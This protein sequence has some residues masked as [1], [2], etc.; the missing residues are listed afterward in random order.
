MIPFFFQDAYSMLFKIKGYHFDI[1]CTYHKRWQQDVLLGNGYFRAVTNLFIDSISW[2]TGVLLDPL[3]A[4][5]PL[6]SVSEGSDSDNDAKKPQAPIK[7][8]AGKGKW[9]GED[10]DDDTPV[11]SDYQSNHLSIRPH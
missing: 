10:A 6:I 9:E 11:V 3:H 4:I 1:Y 8:A 7:K 2:L 5:L